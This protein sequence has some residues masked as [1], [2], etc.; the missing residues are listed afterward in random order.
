MK[1]H[2]QI[3]LLLFMAGI[4]AQSQKINKVQFFEDTSIIN[5]T[6]AVNISN[7]FKN[8]QTKGYTTQAF[9]TCSMA[10]GKTVADSIQLEIRGN[11]RREYC[12]IPPLKIDFKYDSNCVLSPLKTLKLVS[13]CKSFKDNDQYLLMEYLVYRIY[14][15]LTDKSFRVRLLQLKLDDIESQRKD[16][17]SYAF[18]IEDATDMAKRNGCKEQKQ[19]KFEQEST[20]RYQTTMVS[21]FQYMIGNTDWSTLARHN[22]CL[23]ADNKNPNGPPLAVPYDFD[24]SGLVGTTYSIPDEKLGIDDVRERLYRGFPRTEKEINEVLEIFKQKEDAIYKMI[25]EFAILTASSKKYM[26][27]YL[28]TFFATI[29]NPKA[30]KTIFVENARMR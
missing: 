13:K 23:I 30:V 21:I 3:I 16:F 11:F 12:H 28:Q 27:S 20:E 26:T 9:L 19:G 17:A 24:F 22:I 5:A 18:L 6:I 15:L 2:F 25:D 10:D 7:L 8:Y 29:K 4:A 1:K 14:N